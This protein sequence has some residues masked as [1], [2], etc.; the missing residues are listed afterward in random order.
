[1]NAAAD[2][3]CIYAS[4]EWINLPTSGN[5][6]RPLGPPLSTLTS[7]IR[8]YGMNTFLTFSWIRFVQC[9]I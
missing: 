7:V 5:M 6:R 1:M 3:V 9:R 8:L 2:N 4:L